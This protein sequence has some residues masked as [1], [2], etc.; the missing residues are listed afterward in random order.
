MRRI[1]LYRDPKLD[2][3]KRNEICVARGSYGIKEGQEKRKKASKEIRGIAHDR[4]KLKH[5]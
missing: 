1:A 4:G 5:R 2:V 3:D